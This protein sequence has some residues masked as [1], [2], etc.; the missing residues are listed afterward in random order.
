MDLMMRSMTLPEGLGER[1]I[2][3]AARGTEL[4]KARDIA[5][6]TACVA[7]I[8]ALV[9]CLPKTQTGG[10]PDDDDLAAAVVV[11]DLLKRHGMRMQ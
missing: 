5:G 3:L 4:A 2:E 11:Q 10:E 7:E 8:F 9:R 6:A 1:I